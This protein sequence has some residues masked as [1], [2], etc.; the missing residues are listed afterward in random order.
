[1]PAGKYDHLGTEIQI[2]Q[3]RVQS[4]ES[5]LPLFVNQ[6]TK[7]ILAPVALLF[8]PGLKLQQ[9]LEDI[10]ACRICPGADYGNLTRQCNLQISLPTPSIFE[11]IGA[12]SILEALISDRGMITSMGLSV[13]SP[14]AERLRS[15]RSM[16]L[17]SSG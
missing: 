1:M 5:A 14:W 3:S 9:T 2:R 16:R 15:S 6:Q 8:L 11:T 12:Y 13:I 4:R 17:F 7:G 10:E